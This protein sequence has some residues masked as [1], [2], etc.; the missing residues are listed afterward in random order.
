MNPTSNASQLD[1]AV[2]RFEQAIDRYKKAIEEIEAA[3]KAKNLSDDPLV[4]EV[5]IYF[6]S[7]RFPQFYDKYFHKTF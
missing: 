3:D 2:E 4:M 6:F 7:G 1:I 5:P